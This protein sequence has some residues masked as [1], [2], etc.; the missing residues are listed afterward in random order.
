MVQER[1][2]QIIGIVRRE[3]AALAQRAETV[4]IVTSDEERK[5]FPMTRHLHERVE[6]IGFFGRSPGNKT[7]PLIAIHLRSLHIPDACIIEI[8]ENFGE[9]HTIR[10]MIG[11]KCR[12]DLVSIESNLMEPCIIV[13]VLCGLSKHAHFGLIARKRLAAE[14]MDAKRGTDFLDS[15]VIPLIQDPGVVRIVEPHQSLQ[16][17]FQHIEWL[18]TRHI[19]GH[20]GD[21]PAR[22]RRKSSWLFHAGKNQPSP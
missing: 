2:Q 22:S 15:L 11:I 16:G 5:A 1:Q 12:Q 19:R 14:M 8:P 9:I 4:C 17:L 18:N 10:H 21:L 13:S 3:P 20:N 7:R 6:L